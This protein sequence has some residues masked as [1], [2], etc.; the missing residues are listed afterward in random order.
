MKALSK[1]QEKEKASLVD[2]IRLASLMIWRV[3]RMS[4]E[5]LR[6]ERVKAIIQEWLDQ[7]G[8][9]RCWYYPE[10]FNRL[11]RELGLTSTRAP[12]LPSREEFEEGCRQYI[13]EQYD[14]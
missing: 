12:G 14:Q 3:Y 8:H 10:L 7:Q 13:D 6:L 4:P 1:D 9:D 11:A 5:G 2:A